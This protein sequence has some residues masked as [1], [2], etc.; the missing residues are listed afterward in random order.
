MLNIGARRNSDDLLLIGE[1][2]PCPNQPVG[3]H[4]TTHVDTWRSWILRPRGSRGR[5]RALIFNQSSDLFPG[6]VSAGFALR[7]YA[8]K[9]FLFG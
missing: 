1:D 4:W 8:L 9:S 2:A 5:C 7:N 6:A 3:R